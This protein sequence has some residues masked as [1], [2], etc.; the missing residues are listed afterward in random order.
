[1]KANMGGEFY[2]LQAWRSVKFVSQ[3]CF[4]WLVFLGF[5]AHEYG[6]Y[7]EDFVQCRLWHGVA[8][9]GV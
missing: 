7:G 1:M 5:H 9:V 8:E 2:V 3:S 4:V 6:V